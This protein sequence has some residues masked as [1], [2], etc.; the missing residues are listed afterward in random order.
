MERN[1]PIAHPQT[2]FTQ[3]TKKNLSRVSV[4]GCIYIH[5]NGEGRRRRRRRSDTRLEERRKNDFCEQQHIDDGKKNTR[6]KEGGRRQNNEGQ[7]R[8]QQ[9]VVIQ[10]PFLRVF[11]FVVN[12]LLF[13]EVVFP[14]FF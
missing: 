14:L 8:K 9:K 13:A 12:V 10:L 5:N 7:R 4:G 1:C 3:L 6:G 11:F 2:L